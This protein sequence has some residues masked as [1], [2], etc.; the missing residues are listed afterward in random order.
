[1]SAAS[2]EFSAG[3][4][5]K[6]LEGYGYRRYD[7]VAADCRLTFDNAITYNEDGSEV[8]QRLFCIKLLL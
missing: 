3:T 8:L 5:K 6:K 2:H 1:M 7:D 4:I